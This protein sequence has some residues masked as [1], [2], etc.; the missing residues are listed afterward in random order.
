M[1]RRIRM[2]V[3]LALC[4]SLALLAHAVA[5]VARADS[6]AFCPDLD[7][8]GRI[9]VV[10]VMQVAAHLGGAD[11]L[12]DLDRN[13]TV[14]Q[15]DVVWIAL[16][17]RQQPAATRR[18]NVPY[19]SSTIRPPET[20]IFWFGAL[21]ATRN[22]ADVRVG[23]NDRELY[24]R[25]A[26]FDR[27]LWYDTTP[28]ATDLTAWDAATVYLNLDGNTGAAPDANSFRVTGQLNW[29]ETPRTPWQAAAQGNGVGWV[30]A[31][32]PFTLTTSWRG[33]APNDAVDD[34]GWELR[35]RLPFSSLGLSGPPPR[36]TIWG[37]GIVLHDRD[38]A[39]GT[40]I[41]DQTWP[42]TL[43]PNQPASWGQ[44]AFGVPPYTPPSAVPGAT[45]VVRHQLDGAVVVDGA[46][47]GG[48]NCSEGH[49]FW[50][51]WGDL[52][53]GGQ[54]DFNIQNQFDVADRPCFSRAY[55]TFPLT[56]IPPGRVV[57]SATLTLHQFGNSDPS[58]ARP[59][60]I[61]VLTVA[62]A[63][64]EAT[65]TWNRAP[66]ASENVGGAWV[67]PLPAF[68]GWP[69]V[70]RTWDVSRATAEA[71]AR[72]APLRLALYS[73]D[74]DYHSGKYFVS[75]DTGDWNATARPTLRVLWGTP[76]NR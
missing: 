42:P 72:G 26:A 16:C 64:D 33:N 47:G 67:D 48:F 19:F 66:L 50:E 43:N 75:S 69:G 70:P 15:S 3:W 32:F 34:N 23:Y 12:Y 21:D 1:R 71:Y 25:L 30:A 45:V 41:A 2:L 54:G 68:P 62:E 24:L 9:D 65:L 52:N 29:W 22:S 55:L 58:Q 36:G 76:I 13:G 37:L 60:F 49:D 57:L 18:V 27:R 14:A 6:E 38:D 44:M 17:W 11:P 59:S 35:L 63:W 74:V 7:A 8:N 4:L 56:A 53:Y 20:A 10:D 46:V 5:V 28:T 39:A 40:P 73:A 61:Q 51:G 31:T